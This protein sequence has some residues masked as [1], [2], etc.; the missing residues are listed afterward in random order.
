MK[1]K[2]DE[3]SHDIKN[4]VLHTYQPTREATTEIKEIMPAS[5]TR[6]SLPAPERKLVYKDGTNQRR[7][8]E[9]WDRG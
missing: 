3:K 5:S 9:K 2:V 1:P 8:A 4:S 6:G 7:L